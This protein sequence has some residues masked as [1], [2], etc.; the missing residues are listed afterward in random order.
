VNGGAAPTAYEVRWHS[1]PA[2]VSTVVALV[3]DAGVS[4]GRYALQLGGMGTTTAVTFLDAPVVLAA[5]LQELA[6]VGNVTVTC[7]LHQSPALPCN[8][9]ASGAPRAVYNLT[10]VTYL[11]ASG[12]SAAPSLTLVPSAAEPLVGGNATVCDAAAV[13]SGL[14]ECAVPGVAPVAGVAVPDWCAPGGDV[15]TVP[16]RLPL[17]VTLAG[18]TPGVPVLATVTAVDAAGSGRTS[19]SPTPTP[20]D[21]PPPPPSAAAGRGARRAGAAGARRAAP[22]TDNGAPVTRYDVLWSTDAAGTTPA[23]VATCSPPTMCTAARGDAPYFTTVTYG[24]APGV[25]VYLRVTAVNAA[26]SSAASAVVAV[27]PAD[28]P[29]QLPPAAVSLAA[30]PAS[31]AV[32]VA[33]A[34]SSLALSWRGSTSAGTNGDAVTAYAVGWHAGAPRSEVQ[35]LTLAAASGGS[36]TVQWGGATTDH[37]PASVDAAA[38]T[39]ALGALPGLAGIVVESVPAAAL[40]AGERAWHLTFA[41]EAGGLGAP[42]AVT[43]WLTPAVTANVSVTRGLPLLS[44]VTTWAVAADGASASA[45]GDWTAQLP[46]GSWV[47]WRSAPSVPAVDTTARVS[48]AAYDGST[49]TLTL[50]PPSLSVAGQGSLYAAGGATVV[51]AEPRDWHED[52]VVVG[53]LGTAAASPSPDGTVTYSYT[54]TG[55]PVG[56]RVTAVVAPVNALGAAEWR[57]STPAALAPP[58]QVPDVPTEVVLEVASGTSLRT[59]WRAP[60]SDGGAPVSKYV[61]EWAPV[62]EPGAAQQVE[63][64]PDTHGNGDCVAA[65]CEAVIAGLLTGTPYAVRV[66]AYNA[67]GFSSTPGV[68]TPAAA[69]PCTAPGAPGAVTSAALNDTA[70]RVTWRAPADDGGAAVT[71]YLVEWDVAWLRGASALAVSALPPP[72]YGVADVYEV[73]VTAATNDLAGSVRLAYRGYGTGDLPLVSSPEALAA[74]LADLPVVGAGVEVSV[75]HHTGPATYGVSWVITFAAGDSGAA[76]VLTV[77]SDGGQSWWPVVGGATTGASLSPPAARAAVIRRAVAGAGFDTQVVTVTPVAGTAAFPALPVG[78]YLTLDGATTPLLPLN[79]SAVEVAAALTATTAAGGVTVS[80]VVDASAIAF[81]IAFTSRL[82]RQPALGVTLDAPALANAVVTKAATGALPPMGSAYAGSVTVAATPAP[83]ADYVYDVAGLPPGATVYARVSAWNGVTA[84]YGGRAQA[85]PGAL[86]LVAT[87]GRPE[88]VV[89]NP[90]D[91]ATLAVSWAQPLNA[92]TAPVASYV[93]E[94][95]VP[96]GTACVQDVVLQ[97]T[98]LAGTF[99]LARDAA[100]TAPLPVNASAILVA[101]A[102]N[103]L[104]NVGRVVVNAAPASPGGRWWVTFV[105]VPGAVAPLALRLEGVYGTPDRAAVSVLT[106]GALTGLTSPTNLTVAAGNEVQVV[107]VSAEGGDLRGTFRLVRGGVASRPIAVSATSEVATAL[108]AALPRMPTVRV[109][110]GVAAPRYD[111]DAPA[112]EFVITFDAAGGPQPLL[113]VSTDDGVTAGV[114][115]AGGS[116][117]GTHTLAEVTRRASAALPTS[118]AIPLTAATLAAASTGSGLAVRVTAAGRGRAVAGSAGVARTVVVPRRMPPCPPALVL[119]RTAVPGVADVT[120][121]APP[122]DGG[123][124]V[125]T[126]LVEWDAT[127]AFTPSTS[128]SVAVAVGAPDAGRALWHASVPLSLASLTAAT[129]IRVSAASAVG[130][131]APAPASAVEHAGPTASITLVDDVPR[132][133]RNPVTSGTWRLAAALPYGRVVATGAL[134]HDDSGAAVGDALAAAG[135]ASA[136]ALLRVTR[137]DTRGGVADCTDGV[138]RDD[139]LHWRLDISDAAPPALTPLLATDA[140]A[141]AEVQYLLVATPAASGVTGWV[142]FAVSSAAGAATS[143][144]LPAATALTPAGATAALT[145]LYPAGALDTVTSVYAD[146]PAAGSAALTTLAVKWTDGGGDV[147]LLAVTAC[148]PVDDAAPTYVTVLPGR[149]GVALAPL[150]PVTAAVTVT[151]LAPPAAALAPGFVAVGGFASPPP[152]TAVVL[153]VVSEAQLGVAWRAPAP[154][155][156]AGTAQPT[157]VGYAVEWSAYAAYDDARAPDVTAARRARGTLGAGGGPPVSAGGGARGVPFPLDSLTPLAAGVP[158]WV[159]VATLWAA[160]APLAAGGDAPLLTFSL[161]A[162]ASPAPASPA[163]QLPYAPSAAAVS[164]ASAAAGVT[165]RNAPSQLNVT[166]WDPVLNARRFHTRDGSAANVSRITAFLLEW[167]TAAAFDSGAGG[168]PAGAALMPNYDDG[169]DGDDLAGTS[170]ADCSGAAGCTFALG[171]EVQVVVV[172]HTTGYAPAATVSYI[173]PSG[174]ATSCVRLDAPAVALAAA[175][176]GA[177]APAADAAGGG[178]APSV[179]V[180]RRNRLDG[181]VMTS[182]AYYVTF[183]GAAVVGDVATLGLDYA[184]CGGVDAGAVVVNTPVAGGAPGPRGPGGGGGRAAGGRGGGRAPP[185]GGRRPPGAPRPAGRPRRRPPAARPPPRHRAGPAL[186]ATLQRRRLAHR[187]LQHDVRGGG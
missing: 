124:P 26:G 21:A 36:F 181:A 118:A 157:V 144:C 75:V 65:P 90:T 139:G 148:A 23:A 80:K 105:S 110:V 131:S 77:S 37:L 68:S 17:E 57:A 46:V 175:L 1:A 53:E 28:K 6:G 54:I 61:V 63:V 165:F 164:P 186:A 83:A 25:P 11:N 9:S 19:A 97:G 135:A 111:G 115:K 42:L 38:L 43:S 112:T 140:D 126:Y 155:A 177:L 95:G 160:P 125:T 143:P 149:D 45:P 132:A 166:V 89:A 147:P 52:I 153:S 5:A 59:T 18:L 173:V 51:G 79:A 103:R 154:P 74:A 137:T 102:L 180:A 88:A 119:A 67:Y 171:A 133:S 8:A 60:D 104:E 96:E 150:A 50:A 72:L 109:S 169:S 184:S 81:T 146:P 41:P 113:L 29:A 182:H 122:C 152:P 162:P 71:H 24:L 158:V 78:M 163:R 178:L 47:E 114:A 62:A 107:R 10:F 87:P 128:Q 55:L 39:A 92:A 40:Q 127:G 84:A 32:R 138:V 161:P 141:T 31:D 16:A 94:V 187:L 34:I 123:S 30:I 3:V 2:A 93:V 82:G 86:R 70:A 172:S 58:P 116:L 145:P 15:L 185:P 76:D 156:T 56:R 35:R 174:A 134:A 108:V 120:W 168:T 64:L 170:L 91:P 14:A 101:D 100:V 176:N 98:G 69:A 44:A 151:T 121:R 130:Y 4:S 27:T 66:Y 179:T 117:A 33:D 7:S 48:G 49:T 73:A 136:G 183:L 12:S 106:P 129:A 20:P 142:Q 159:R 13:A 99:R 85:L 22:A 167:D